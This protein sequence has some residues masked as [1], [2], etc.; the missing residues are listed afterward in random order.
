MHAVS[1]IPSEQHRRLRTMVTPLLDSVPTIFVGMARSGTTY[2]SEIARFNLKIACVNEGAFEFWLADQ[3]CRPEVLRQDA[4]L[5]GLLKGLG[6]HLFFQ[7]LYGKEHNADRVAE[8][9]RP[10]VEDRTCQGIALA[11]LKLAAQ[12]WKMSRLAHED[13]VFMYN[14]EK[15]LDMYPGCRLVQIVRDPR[16]VAASVLQFPWGPNNE[17][18][19]AHDWNRMVGRVRRIGARMGPS[20]YL[21]FRY[22]DLLQKPVETFSALARFTTGVA[23]PDRVAEFERQMAANPLR[24]NYHKW[25]QKFTPQQVQRIEAA[26]AQEMAVYGYEPE[27]PH[28]HLSAA[29]VKM[30]RLHH[31]AVQLRN[32]LFGKLKLN[33]GGIVDPHP[34]VPAPKRVPDRVTTEVS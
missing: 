19:A 26:A 3:D 1:G 23:D 16:D 15:I 12:R 32:M 6:Q 27:Q 29:S 30:W 10:L 7:F 4:A 5:D 24:R 17:V 33:G 8:E 34:P 9:L 22:E 20:R 21:E 14:P 2:L 28:V 25:N 31:R 13:P 18:V 11:V